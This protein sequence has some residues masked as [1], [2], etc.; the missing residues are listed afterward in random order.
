MRGRAQ[1]D[2]AP[3][4]APSPLRKP[5]RARLR[6]S[7][8]LLDVVAQ[9]A[10]GSVIQRLPER[11][12]VAETLNAGMHGAAAVPKRAARE[13]HD[14]IV[15][16]MAPAEHAP[17]KRVAALHPIGFV[18]HSL[19]PRLDRDQLLRQVWSD[20]LIGIQREDPLVPGDRDT[21]VALLAD[22]AGTVRD[23]ARTLGTRER[24]RV[25]RG[26]AVDDHDIVGPGEVPDTS[27]DL[28]RLIAGG[29]D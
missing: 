28:F 25:V 17:L 10:V 19:R 15:A 26:S 3:A 24:H 12:D 13:A 8:Q 20:A 27:D 22:A 7:D 14:P 2:V 1:R 11:P 4:R 16:P 29:N 9:V 6:V 23:D 5:T 18:R 21:T